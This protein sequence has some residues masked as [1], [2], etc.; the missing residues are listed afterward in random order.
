MSVHIRSVL[1]VHKMFI[2]YW[3]VQILIESILEKVSWDG[4]NAKDFI[5]PV[6]VSGFLNLLD[7]DMLSRVE[8]CPNFRICGIY[9]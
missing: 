1:T 7:W 2:D 3:D 5:M 9:R 8:N 6:D 4:C